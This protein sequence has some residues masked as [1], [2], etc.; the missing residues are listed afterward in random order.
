MRKCLL[1]L[2][3]ILFALPAHAQSTIYTSSSGVAIG[4]T[5]PTTGTA[6][7]IGS[8]TSSVLLPIGTTGQRPTG[9]AGM[10]RYNSTNSVPEVYTGSW[11]P[12]PLTASSPL[13]IN[14]TTGNITCPTCNTSSANV[15]SVSGDGAFY[16]N[17]PPARNFV[18]QFSGNI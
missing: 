5:S 1:A 14:S 6:L 15:N 3:V 2:A 13:A 18:G 9:V 10:L 8:K 7:D 4:T 17:S 12:V 16:T 11:L